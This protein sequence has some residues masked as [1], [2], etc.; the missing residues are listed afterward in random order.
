MTRPDVSACLIVRDAAATLPRCL[1][2][3][4]DLVRE[5]VVVDT[6]STDRTRAVAESFGA[7]VY[8]FPWTD[9]FSAAR[10]EAQ[11]HATGRWVLCLDAD[12]SF[13]EPNRQKLRDL[14]ERLGA[15]AAY[16]LTQ[17][18]LLANGS[19]LDLPHTR[20]FRNHRAIRWQYRVHEQIAPAA[21]RAGH[22]LR[23]TD[24]VL[25]HAGYEDAGTHRRKT[26][27][28]ARLLE[29]DRKQR[30]HDPFILFNLATAYAD[31]GRMAEAVPLLRQCVRLPPGEDALGRL[32]YAALVQC[33]L[34][35]GRADEAWTTCQEGRRQYADAVGLLFLQAQLL[36]NRGD[37]VGAERALL[38]LARLKPGPGAETN[39]AAVRQYVAPHTLGLV[40]AAQGRVA[41]AERQWQAVVA[42]HPAYKPSGQ[43]L[44]ELYLG[45]QRWADLEAL[46]GQVAARPEWSVDAPVLRA[47][48]HL[49]KGE[50]AAA[51]TLLEGLIARAP[52]ALAPRFYLTHVLMAEGRDWPAAER[53]LHEVLRLDPAQAQ[54]WYNLTVVLRRQH[55]H[56]EARE[57]CETGLRRCPGDPHLGR[58]LQAMR[59]GK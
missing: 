2:S 38:E 17:R 28:N 15:D 1:G 11:R 51:R 59:E 41:D 47:R 27:R 56:R 33:H 26:E 43:V 25:Q 58:M 12:E 18:S 45:Q 14:L 22:P 23:T 20:L 48:L 57:A 21:R 55:K 35:A 30:P 8:N 49:T 4:A 39:D 3:V 10:N 7:R 37:L 36:Q 32:A 54:C 9:D 46:L 19:P 40:Y 42:L 24:I 5:I 34:R 29:L 50:L 13:D 6:G 53:A 44:A 31:L 16:T 52:D